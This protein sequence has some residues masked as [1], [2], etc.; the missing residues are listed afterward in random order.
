MLR[1]LFVRGADSELGKAVREENIGRFL[2]ECGFDVEEAYLHMPLTRT[3]VGKAEGIEEIVSFLP[4][5]FPLHM[6]NISPLDRLAYVN[7]SMGVNSIKKVMRKKGFDVILAETASYVGLVAQHVAQ[8][9]SIPCIVDVQGLV[10]AECRGSG[11]K[12]WYLEESRE[13]HAVRKCDHVLVVSDAMKRFVEDHYDVDPS[14]V[15]VVTN[16]A[17]V[18]PFSASYGFPLKV[19]YAGCF[20][21]WEKITDYLVVAKSADSNYFNFYLAGPPDERIL[22]QIRREHIPITYIGYLPKQEMP[23]VMAGMQ[24]G[25]AP[26]TKD[27]AR[28][29]AFPIKILDYMACGLPVIAPKVGSWGQM[30]E[31]ENCGVALEEDRVE[32]YLEALKMLSKRDVWLEKSKNGIRAIRTDYN[33]DKVL[34]PLKHVLMEIEKNTQKHS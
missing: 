29:V 3:N 27:L 14:K 31:E 25:I 13:K 24:I 4:S 5:M 15:T 28:L 19:I 10:G 7:F 21:Y 16:G 23:K 32:D 2:R 17:D 20:S 30:I 12:R 33:W 18:L 34:L 26:S 9:A 11:F 6:S 22:S 8:E 1:I